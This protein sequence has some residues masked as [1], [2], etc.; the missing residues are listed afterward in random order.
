[1]STGSDFID[2]SFAAQ[3]FDERSYRSLPLDGI[4]VIDFI[5]SGDCGHAA[6]ADDNASHNIL[7]LGRKARAGGPPVHGLSIE[8]RWSS[9]AG[10]RR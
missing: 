7:Y 2:I 10:R 5:L 6:C 1:M 9:Q 3:G 4:R 8:P